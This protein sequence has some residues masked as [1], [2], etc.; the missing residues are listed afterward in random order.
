MS[1]LGTVQKK[2]IVAHF[3]DEN[4]TKVVLDAD[5]RLIVTVET[6]GKEKS[7]GFLPDGSVSLP[8]FTLH[9]KNVSD[10]NSTYSV[11]TVADHGLWITSET[12]NSGT[13]GDINI[14][15]EYDADQ[16]YYWI[17][18]V[19]TEGLTYEL[20]PEECV[21]CYISPDS[22]NRAIIIDPTVNAS[23]TVICSNI[24]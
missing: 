16:K 6:N 3:D 21:N 2:S 13:E 24:S 1:E 4:I 14:L 22:P 20:V 23:G 11:A 15:F 17:G 9:V 7:M 12:I 10:T 8:V 18:A 5:E 19:G